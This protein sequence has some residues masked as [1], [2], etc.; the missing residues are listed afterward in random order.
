MLFILIAP[1]LSSAESG[2][3]DVNLTVEGCN[4]NSICELFL[5]ENSTNCPLDCSITEPSEGEEEYPVIETG[6]RSGSRILLPPIFIPDL[7]PE[8][9]QYPNVKDISIHIVNKNAKLS[10]ENPQNLNFEYVRIMKNDIFTISPYEGYVIYEGVGQSFSDLILEFDKNYYY[11]FFVKYK[12]GTYS[13]A[14]PIMVNAKNPFYVDEEGVNP[15][16]PTKQVFFNPKF[17]IFELSITQNNK[18]LEWKDKLLQAQSGIPVG[19]KLP[20]KNFFGPINDV[21]VY[22]DFYNTERN[23]LRQEIFKMNYNPAFE[24]YETEMAGIVSGEKVFFEVV[25]VDENKVESSVSGVIVVSRILQ[26][27]LA[28]LKKCLGNSVGWDKALMYLKCDW[29]WIILLV[30]FMLILISLQ[31]IFLL[32]KT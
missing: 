1:I 28:T 17:N 4:N 31:K 18:Q 13:V 3:V 9:L 29:R 7:L 23:F 26:E 24:R 22:A 6:G 5:N 15:E 16:K 14:I 25:L 2:V 27:D 12:D 8:V 11:T 20:K 30:I 32:K 21:Y 19:I 10:W